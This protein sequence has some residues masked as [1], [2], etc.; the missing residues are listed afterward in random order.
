MRNS[1][2]ILTSFKILIFGA[3]RFQRKQAPKKIFPR[4][5]NTNF[6][7]PLQMK[8]NNDKKQLKLK[9]VSVY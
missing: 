4:F 8:L 5:F 1:I 2:L 6:H 3:N 7:F 9:N